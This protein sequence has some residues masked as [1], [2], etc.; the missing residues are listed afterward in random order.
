MA[1][2]TFPLKKIMPAYFDRC[3]SRRWGGVNGVGVAIGSLFVALQV[4]IVEKSVRRKF[5]HAALAHELRV[6]VELPQL[7]L[8]LVV[9]VQVAA[10]EGALRVKLVHVYRQSV[11]NVL[12]G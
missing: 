1:V 7:R 4:E 11:E 2:E 9:L 3:G 5:V 10:L 6:T 12:H 8:A